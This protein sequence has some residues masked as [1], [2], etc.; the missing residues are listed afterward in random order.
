M[1]PRWVLVQAGYRNRFG[2]PA[3]EAL[4]RYAAVGAEP[5]ASPRCGAMRWHSQQPG[6]LHCQRDTAARYWHHRAP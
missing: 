3:P 1:R 6:A 2:H 4:A 5:V